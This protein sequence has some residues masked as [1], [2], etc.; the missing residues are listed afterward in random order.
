M[1]TKAPSIGSD[2]NETVVPIRFYHV[3]V[4]LI[5]VV[6]NVVIISTR[7]RRNDVYEI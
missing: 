7:A 5:F 4:M 1:L 6:V 3:T 2:R